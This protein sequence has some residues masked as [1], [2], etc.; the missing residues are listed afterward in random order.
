[1]RIETLFEIAHQIEPMAML[2]PKVIDFP[3]SDAMF[4]GAGAVH[5]QRTRDQAVIQPSRFPDF[6]RIVGVEH[7]FDVKIAVADMPNDG[8]KQR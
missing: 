6:S 3:K 4:S 1:M 5:G 7:E 2:V 8:R